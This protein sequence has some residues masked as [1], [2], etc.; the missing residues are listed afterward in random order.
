M[1]QVD[2]R[3]FQNVPFVLNTD[4]EGLYRDIEQLCQTLNIHLDISFQSD[5]PATRIDL[6][7]SG[8]CASIF[9]EMTLQSLLS[10][11]PKDEQMHF[12]PFRQESLIY[13]LSLAY[14]SKAFLPEY[15]REFIRIA[16]DVTRNKKR[17]VTPQ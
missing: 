2:L 1:E 12:F 5:D 14:H 15:R 9:P 16:A 4:G 17:K 7:Q 8:F 11:I 10:K 6:C 3:R 13:R